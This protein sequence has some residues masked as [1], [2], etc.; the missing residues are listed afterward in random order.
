MY[1]LFFMAGARRVTGMYRYGTRKGQ[2]ELAIDIPKP[3]KVY[4]AY[5]MAILPGSANPEG[6]AQAFQGSSRVDALRT[7]AYFGNACMALPTQKVKRRPF[8]HQPG[9]MAYAVGA[10]NPTPSTTHDGYEC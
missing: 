2:R 9:W 5:R 10:E 1:A 4:G 7:L 8:R 3:L 6:R